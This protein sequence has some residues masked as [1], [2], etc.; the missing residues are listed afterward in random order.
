VRIF[1]LIELR[2]IYAIYKANTFTIFYTRL[3]AYF[4]FLKLCEPKKGDVV[5]VNAAAGA[6]LNIKI[7]ENFS[8]DV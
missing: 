1:S 7:F 5:V 4:G 8:S 6:G 2:L 3:T